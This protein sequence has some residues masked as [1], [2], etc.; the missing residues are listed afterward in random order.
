LASELIKKPKIQVT[1]MSRSRREQCIGNNAIEADV[2]AD[3][4][5]AQLPKHAD[6]L[7]HLAQ[8]RRYREFP[9]GAEDMLRVNTLSTLQLMD[10]ARNAGVMRVLLASTGTV[11][12]S[13]NY[14]VAEDAPC[15][16]STMY[17]ISKYSAEMIARVYQSYF[18]I[19]IMRLFTVYGPGQ[20]GMIVP[21]LVDNIMMG[22]SITLARGVGA[23]LT[24]IYID[25][26]LD[27]MSA[28]I[29]G[30][31]ERSCE[32]YNLAGNE[33][34]TM[35]RMVEVI[36]ELLGI[37]PKIQTSDK[38]LIYAMGDNSRIVASCGTSPKWKFS[39]GAQVVVKEMLR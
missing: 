1:C 16:P 21:N 23:V 6:C 2:I 24:P 25:D 5:T 8:S 27:M 29:F 13:Q 26:C 12:R 4:W 33:V 28:L 31:V 9:D 37:C 20:R 7:V 22:R 39:D 19:V 36:S 10:W 34:L 15:D 17:S 3:G 18:Q 35:H 30:D 32:I 38:P 11:Y 14:K